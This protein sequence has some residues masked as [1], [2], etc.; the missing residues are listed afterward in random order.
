MHLILSTWRGVSS[1]SAMRPGGHQVPWMWDFYPIQGPW[2]A[3][4][5]RNL[6][7]HCQQVTDSNQKV[8]SGNCCEVS[9]RTCS[10]PTVGCDWVA[11]EEIWRCWEHHRVWQL[12]QDGVTKRQDLLE[13]PIGMWFRLMSWMLVQGLNMRIFRDLPINTIRAS[14]RFIILLS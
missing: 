6:Q 2:E 14:T 8:W 9:E 1:C 13:V 11:Q 3:Q 12:P 7:I 4:L 5:P 10:L